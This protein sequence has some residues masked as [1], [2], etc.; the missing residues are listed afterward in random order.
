M[1]F[2]WV[3]GFSAALTGIEALWYLFIILNSL[4]GLFV[5]LSFTFNGQVKKLW[6]KRLTLARGLALTKT[7][8]VPSRRK[9]KS[10]TSSVSA[11]IAASESMEMSSNPT[12]CTSITSDDCCKATPEKATR[13][14]AV[15][16]RIKAR[17]FFPT[18][19]TSNSKV[20]ESK[21]HGA[22]DVTSSSPDY[23]DRV[24]STAYEEV[25]LE[26]GLN[27]S[28]EVII[29]VQDQEGRFP[30]E[31]PPPPPRP[32][33]RLQHGLE[34]IQGKGEPEAAE[35]TSLKKRPLLPCPRPLPNNENYILEES[36]SRPII[37]QPRNIHNEKNP[38]KDYPPCKPL[39]PPR[40]RGY[41]KDS[42][43]KEHETEAVDNLSQAKPL[44][45]HRQSP[46]TKNVD[47]VTDRG[48]HDRPC[49][50]VPQGIVD[51]DQ[52]DTDGR[53]PP[54][55]PPPHSHL[56]IKAR[57]PGSAGDQ[58]TEAASP[59]PKNEKP[60][61]VKNPNHNPCR[62]APK[63]ILAKDEGT[64]G[65]FPLKKPPPL[66]R[67]KA[68]PPAAPEVTTVKD[69]E[70]RAAGNMSLSK[71]P[72]LPRQ[73]PQPMDEKHVTE[74]SRA[75][76]SFTPQDFPEEDERD[77]QSTFPPERPPPPPRPNAIPQDVLEGLGASQWQAV[78]G[79]LKGKSNL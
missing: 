27:T 52:K 4:Q 54:N 50:L 40:P 73:S 15:L 42:T 13:L 48:Y 6:Q 30:P 37:F 26:K 17:P 75:T 71:L 23:T 65:R 38:E 20:K 77:L 62:L 44:I 10:T 1:G 76:C 43:E 39:P 61:I 19:P 16:S 67:L 24:T 18:G 78:I 35:N 31:K 60:V 59:E 58:E 22:G 33:L 72:F 46:Q 8:L 12:I 64:D 79:Q 57:P 56:R 70:T 63:D 34:D 3:F 25:I 66:P 41:L 2:T 68:R 55:K 9:S 21:M 53:F 49:R 11:G 32:K 36:I 28:A 47:F 69:Q 29:P 51:K 45:L 74:E 5:F 14:K 7:S